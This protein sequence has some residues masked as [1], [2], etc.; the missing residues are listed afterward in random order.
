MLDLGS[1]PGTALFAA[2]EEFHLQQATLLESDAAWLALGKRLSRKFQPPAATETQWL[3]QDLRSVISV[4]PHDLV[5]I[6][7][8]LGELP[9]AAAEALLRKAWSCAQNSLC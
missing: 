7:Y 4:R 9:Q 5:V 8:T 2:S 3:Q 1:G 6:S